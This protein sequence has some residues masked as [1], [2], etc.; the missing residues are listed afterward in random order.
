MCLQGPI[1]SEACCIEPQPLPPVSSVRLVTLR[2]QFY[3][4]WFNTLK[5]IHK[6][7]ILKNKPICLHLRPSSSLSLKK[8]VNAFMLWLH[9]LLS[10]F[11]FFFLSLHVQKTRCVHLRCRSVEL[12]GRQ[13]WGMQTCHHWQRV[14][15]KDFR[16]T[17]LC[18]YVFEGLFI[19]SSNS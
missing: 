15:K 2:L 13:R 3:W 4:G 8:N 7:H 14:T 9:P 17:T 16:C 5:L 1:I 6:Q 12:H 11:L 19:I 10:V 18:A